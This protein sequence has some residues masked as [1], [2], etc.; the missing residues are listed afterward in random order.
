MDVL[1]NWGPTKLASLADWRQHVV[2]LPYSEQVAI[3]WVNCR[4][5]PNGEAAPAR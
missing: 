1:R 5:A 3:R 2:T 4:P